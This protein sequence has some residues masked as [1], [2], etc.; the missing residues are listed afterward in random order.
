MAKLCAK[1]AFFALTM[2]DMYRGRGIPYQ[3]SS[4][5]IRLYKEGEGYICCNCF[6][7]RV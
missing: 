6:S 1:M 3:T 2:L 5:F 7:L 4:D